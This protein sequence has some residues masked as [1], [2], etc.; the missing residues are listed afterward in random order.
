M[1][2]CRGFPGHSVVKTLTS[3]TKHNTI[4]NRSS[5]V[6]NPIKTLKNG[7]H[8]KVF[9][10]NVSHS[11]LGLTLLWSF[12]L[13]GMKTHSVDFRKGWVYAKDICRKLT[14]GFI[15]RESQQ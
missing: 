2:P 11:I 8:K 15:L 3:K 9:K 5:V 12:W 10:K 1:V 6:T 14:C 4:Q 13:Q 7:L